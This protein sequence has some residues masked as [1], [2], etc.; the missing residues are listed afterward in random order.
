MQDTKYT[1]QDTRW[2]LKLPLTDHLQ[3]KRGNSVIYF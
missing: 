2:L 3:S 1:I